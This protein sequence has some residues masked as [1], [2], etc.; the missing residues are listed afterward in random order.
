MSTLEVDGDP[1]SA[2]RAV[3][4]EARKAV[5]I[6][7]AEAICLGC[8]GMAGLEEAIT[9]E[10]H[11]PVID[12]V[13]AAVRLAEAIVGLGL[14]TSKISTYAAPEAKKITAWPLSTALG[15]RPTIPDSGPTS[16]PAGEAVR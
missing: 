10:L 15:L 7:R 5:Q 14:R 11:V 6:D 2:V 8:A 3:V 12:G 13:G 9:S 16:R 1:E 4:A